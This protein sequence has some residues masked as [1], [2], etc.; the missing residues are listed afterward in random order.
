MR[1]ETWTNEA[2]AQERAAITRRDRAALPSNE[3]QK[4][5]ERERER[6]RER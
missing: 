6:E 1:R 3:E 5:L 4:R 2:S